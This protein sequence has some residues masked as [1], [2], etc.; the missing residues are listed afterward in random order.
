MT[1][2]TVFISQVCDGNM[3]IPEDKTNPG[4][5]INRKR[6]LQKHDLSIEHASRVNIDYTGTDYRRYVEVTSEAKGASMRG[7]D[8]QPADAL[9]TREVNHILFL[10][11]A[12]CVGMAVYDPAH[13]ILML[14]HVGRH[15]LEQNGAYTSIKHLV[16][17]YDSEPP[18]LLVWLTPAPGKAHYPLYAFD[19]RDFK[20]VVAEQLHTAGILPHHITDN[21]SDST[22]DMRYFSHS[23]F[24]AGRRTTDGRYAIIAVMQE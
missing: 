22:T 6:F 7:D 24:L 13:Q 16:D 10:P 19:E 2:P 11:L 20:D 5:I 8:I 15:S 14:S 21:P 18:K 3:Y 9:I 4:V 1:T 17:H 23:E 12:D